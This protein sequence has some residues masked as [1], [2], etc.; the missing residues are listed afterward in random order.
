MLPCVLGYLFPCCLNKVLM[1]PWIFVFLLADVSCCTINIFVNEGT[2][3]ICARPQLCNLPK[4]ASVCLSGNFQIQTTKYDKKSMIKMITKIN[5]QVTYRRDQSL[6]AF[7]TSVGKAQ[8]Q[9]EYK[10]HLTNLSFSSIMP[11]FI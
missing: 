10:V 3:P 7:A 6:A 11:C 5:F 8:P 9:D 2:P 1:V 4:E